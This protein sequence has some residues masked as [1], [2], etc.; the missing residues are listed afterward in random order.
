[1]FAT[2]FLQLKG[3]DSKDETKKKKTVLDR[4]YRAIGPNSSGTINFLEEGTSYK[5]R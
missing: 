2:S 3:Y 5:L 1:M 4:L